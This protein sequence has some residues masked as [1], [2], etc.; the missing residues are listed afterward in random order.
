MSTEASEALRADG[1][2]EPEQL[3]AFIDGMQAPAVR[4]LVERH[5]DG[6]GECRAIVGD[7]VAAADLLRS[8]TAAAARR[9]KW[10][11]LAGGL[12]AT[13]ALTVIARVPHTSP[14]DV[15]ERP[16][17]VDTVG[18]APT[19]EPRVTGGAA[20]GSYALEGAA[21]RDYRAL[22]MESLGM[23]L[24]ASRAWEAYLAAESHRGD[25]AA[26]ATP[27]PLR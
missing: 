2:P 14:Y 23:E 7:T 3:A 8:M 11:A 24:E 26:G 19:V 16:V 5:L 1:C 15:P 13:A 27:P 20:Y 4:T 10:L 9:R 12:A 17:V 18:H 21:G 6:C 25:P 22:A